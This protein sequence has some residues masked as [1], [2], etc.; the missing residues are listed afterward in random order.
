MRQ[1]RICCILDQWI[2][3]WTSGLQFFI[4]ISQVIDTLWIV[5]QLLRGKKIILNSSLI[6][7]LLR[8]RRQLLPFRRWPAAMRQALLFGRGSL[9]CIASTWYS[10]ME[11]KKFTQFLS[12]LERALCDCV[13]SRQK[14]DDSKTTLEQRQKYECSPN[15]K[16]EYM[17]LYCGW[18]EPL[19][20]PYYYSFVTPLSSPTF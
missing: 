13:E 10:P 8:K 16:N 7:F 17:S 3:F 11:S 18:Y 15:K 5:G 2:S 1:L 14:Q 6:H 9:A 20:L 12:S 19:L 4:L